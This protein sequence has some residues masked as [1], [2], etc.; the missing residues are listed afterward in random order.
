MSSNSN[1]TIRL[2]AIVG[3]FLAVAAC[4]TP[5][6]PAPPMGAAMGMTIPT[7]A[8]D[9][10][11]QTVNANLTPAQTTWNLRS[12]L[13]VAALN[14]PEPQRTMIVDNYGAFLKRNVR[15]L[16]ATNRA[17]QS[18]F[19]QQYGPAYRDVQDSY[20]TQVY[21]Y[22]ALPP[23]LGNFCDVSYAVSQEALTAEPGDLEVFAARSLPRIEAV[24]DDFYRAYEQYRIDL[25]AWDSQ[26][27]PPTVMTTVQGYTNPL[28]PAYRV[29]PG[30]TVVNSMPATQPVTVAGETQAPVD[31][32]PA[33]G[34][35][36]VIVATQDETT[37][38]EVI[39]LPT[40]GPIFQSGEIVQGETTATMDDTPVP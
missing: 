11:R 29:A 8:T 36:P 6:R 33:S 9:G 2:A 30:E 10:V 27:G 4:T 20:M 39:S 40:Q 5:P 25:A 23:A 19:R 24:F 35:Q 7:I 34:Q 38:E 32:P 1:T 3:G 37:G 15:Q 17:L 21:N 18:E 31:I 22:F 26:Y 12:A 28:D 16:S 13:N 14:C